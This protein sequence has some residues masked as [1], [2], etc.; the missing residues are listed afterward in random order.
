M[1]EIFK[2]KSYGVEGF[3]KI[4]A[5]KRILPSMG[6]DREFINMFI[7]E[8]KIV[9]QLNHANICQIFELSCY[10]NI[11]FIAM[12]Y[13]WGKDVLQIQNRLGKMGQVMNVP[14]ACHIV[15]KVCE[16]LDYAHRKRDPMGAMLEIVHRDCSPQNVLVSYEGEVKIIDFGIAKAASRSSRTMAGVLKGKFGYMS[17]EQVRGLPLD[18][19]TDIFALGTVLYEILTNVRLFQAESDF[20]TLEKVRNVDI[21]PLRAVN[22]SIPVEVEKIVM[23]ALSPDPADRYQWCSEMHA[24]LQR[25]LMSQESVF[26]SKSL[27][28]WMK[29]TFEA[30]LTRER[31]Q[32]EEYRKLGRD[33][34]P[35]GSGEDVAHAVPEVLVSGADDSGPTDSAPTMLGGPDFGGLLDQIAKADEAAVE[36]TQDFAE[37]A[38]TEVF[39][40]GS[41]S[42][43]G[44]HQFAGFAAQEYSAPGRSLP[45]QA[46]DTG[47]NS[48]VVPESRP[49]RPPP[50]RLPSL[51]SDGQEPPTGLPPAVSAANAS[52]GGGRTLLQPSGS[53]KALSERPAEVMIP[54]DHL[55]DQSGGIH[56]DAKTYESTLDLRN[57][58]AANPGNSPN[59]DSSSALPRPVG[60]HGSF[61]FT[62]SVPPVRRNATSSGTRKTSL[63]KD[64]AIGVGIALLVLGV[65]AAIKFFF[66]D[67]NRPAAHLPPTAAPAASLQ[68]VA[69][70]ANSANA[71]AIDERGGT[72]HEDAS[73]TTL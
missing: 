55:D 58:S 15:A 27:A 31:S 66:F 1:A 69:T 30:D 72:F 23:K 41:H 6:E 14:M 25:Y 53:V 70:N 16:G 59:Y 18:R 38:P 43:P 65:F 11:H 21:E 2:A 36:E 19:R 49:P 10:D 68:S 42:S 34:Q 73:S 46:Q 33:G 22:A 9:S 24:D 8:A 60:N 47:G 20:S 56:A 26:T 37:E 13:I 64:V 28:A 71:H 39:G 7:D 51:P 54:G 35:S 67:E 44:L 57:P 61:D 12:E 5:I 29:Q 63:L 52:G 50:S 45:L 4:L 17:P 3:E 48:P 40:E 62:A 32:M